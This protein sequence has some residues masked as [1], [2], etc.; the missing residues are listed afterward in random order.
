MGGHEKGGAACDAAHLDE[1]LLVEVDAEDEHL[2]LC[3]ADSHG[4][5]R[6][7]NPYHLVSYSRTPSARFYFVK[8]TFSVDTNANTATVGQFEIR[9]SS[10]GRDPADVADENP[11]NGCRVVPCAHS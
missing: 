4:L 6:T 5:C 2:E 10:C 11:T 9:D 7:N 1:L 8:S 3:L